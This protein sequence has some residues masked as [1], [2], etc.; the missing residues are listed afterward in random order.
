MLPFTLL[1]PM[2]DLLRSR[3]GEAV[4]EEISAQTILVERAR[5]GDASAWETLYKRAYPKLLAFAARRIGPVDGKDAVNEAMARAVARIDRFEWGRTS[6]DAWLFGILR[7]VVE[8]AKRAGRRLVLGDDELDDQS[9]GVEPG[10]LDHLLGSETSAAVR[11][12][13]AKLPDFD[14]EVLELRVVAGLSSDEVASVVGKRP[15]AVRMAQARALSR[16]RALLEE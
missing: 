13:F 4:E 8:D 7:H 6:F 12:A 14:R 9:L 10:P 5:A 16:L 11:A 1:A 3:R 15:G 2:P